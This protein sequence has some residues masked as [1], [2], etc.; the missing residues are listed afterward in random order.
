M[1]QRFHSN[2]NL[3]VKK[4]VL[5]SA[6]E[7]GRPLLYY[8]VGSC[9]RFLVDHYDVWHASV[10]V[11]ETRAQFL[12]GPGWRRRSK[13]AAG[14]GALA[15]CRRTWWWA[16]RAAVRVSHAS[17]W[18][19]TTVPY[20]S[21]PGSRAFERTHSWACRKLCPNDNQPLADKIY[22]PERRTGSFRFYHSLCLGWLRETYWLCFQA[23]PYWKPHGRRYRKRSFFSK[24]KNIPESTY[25]FFYW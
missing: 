21:R 10:I 1:S 6:P 14:S 2:D 12:I 8:V 18:S 13:K 7:P 9:R 20:L 15:R 4:R 25:A 5:E 24:V 22:T 17:P 16:A 19:T 23:S 3:A 11:Q